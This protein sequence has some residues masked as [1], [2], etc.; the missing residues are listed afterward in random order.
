MNAP[1]HGLE[2]GDGGTRVPRPAVSVVMGTYRGAATI[3]DALRSLARQTL[4]AELFEVLVVQN[5]PP[6]DTAAV[7]DEVCRENPTLCVRRVAYTEPGLGRARNVGMALARG[8]YV[9]FIDDDDTVS[10]RYLEGLLECSAPDTVGAAYMA[11][12]NPPG[13]PPDFS[14]TRLLPQ[15]LHAGSTLTPGEILVVLTYSVGKMLPTALARAVGF[16]TALRSGED[17]D[18]YMRFFTQFPLLVRV[19]P[20]EA[21]AVY[22]RAVVP[23]SLSRQPESYDFNVTQRLDVIERIQGMRLLLAWEQR[24][25]RRMTNSQTTFINRFLRGHPDRHGEVLEDIRRR[26]LSSFSYG[27]LNAW[28]A[29]DLLVLCAAPPFTDIAENGLLRR[30]P[31]AGVVVDVVSANLRR[32]RPLDRST[33]AIWQEY[34]DTAHRVRTRA[35]LEGDWGAI[36]A[37][38]RAGL[39]HIEEREEAKGRYRTI[40][41]GSAYPGSHL[42]AALYKIRNPEVPWTAEFAEPPARTR[43]GTVRAGDPRADEELLTELRKGVVAQ[44]YCAPEVDDPWELAELLPFALADAIVFASES[45]RSRAL[46]ECADGVLAERAYARSVVEPYPVPRAEL[47]RAGEIT[48][49][50]EPGLVHL[51]F[52]GSLTGTRRPAEV[53]AALRALDPAR[54]SLLRLHAFI[55]DGE[56]FAEHARAFGLGDVVVV[57]PPMAYLDHLNLSTRLDVLLVSDAWPTGPRD[58]APPLPPQYLDFVGSGRP[59]WGLVEPGSELGDQP[60]EYRSA[61]GDVG[62]ARAVLRRLADRRPPGP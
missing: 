52:F 3:G 19:T 36:A 23:N 47:Y 44:G 60:L 28:V 7:V 31:E 13:A 33:H 51:G 49:P 25:R 48:Y 11:E 2:A 21:H 9:T 29:R 45:R 41:S 62:G 26:G 6:D 34:T 57:N 4:S 17:I 5:G 38:C 27:R 12:V 39:Q 35:T 18:F 15:L 30:V 20:I 56:G 46:S 16:D 42:L 61:L 55:P 54:R 22:Y 1:P 53:L 32:V 10:A 59:I 40:R 37:F 50:L 43:R 8:A 14:L 58:L 24:G